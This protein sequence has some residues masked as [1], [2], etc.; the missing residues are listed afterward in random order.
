M[1]EWEVFPRV[2][3]ATAVKAQEQG[4]ARLLKTRE[5]LYEAAA[6]IIR[7]SQRATRLLMKEGLIAPAPAGR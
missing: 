6:K 1:D 3:V 4:V 7:E 2:A 5:Q